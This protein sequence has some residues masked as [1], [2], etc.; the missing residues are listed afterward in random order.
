[1]YIAEFT[2]SVVFELSP[3]TLLLPDEPFIMVILTPNI[4]FYLLSKIVS[5]NL[6]ISFNCLSLFYLFCVTLNFLH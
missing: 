4:C 6:Y 1:M 2:L 5:A 3:T